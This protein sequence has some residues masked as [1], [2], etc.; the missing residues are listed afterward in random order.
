MSL[1]AV[2]VPTFLQTLKGL[3]TVLGKAEA[4]CEAKKIAQD[5]LLTAR[6]FPDMFT[7]T[8]Q[9][10]SAGD[11][12]AKT[13]ARLAGV[14]VPT[15]PDVEKSF[16]DL[17]QRVATASRLCQGFH[18]EAVRGRRDA[19]DHRAGRLAQLNFN[20][21]SLLASFALP[22]FFFHATTA[23]DILRTERRRG[24]QARFSRHDLRT[25]T[26]PCGQAASLSRRCLRL[27]LRLPFRLACGTEILAF[28]PLERFR[29]SEETEPTPIAN[30]D[31]G[32]F[33]PHLDNVRIRHLRFHLPPHPAAPTT[34][35]RK[36]FNEIVVLI[37]HDSAAG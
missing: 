8:R 34:M 9:V 2:A 24:R 23:Y 18:R 25:L 36:S 10:Q 14:D 28:H 35:H 5:A 32:R 11:F 17:K 15:Y 37:Q 6:L 26:A 27:R 22:N 16:A 19:R 33:R 1:H 29:R 3:S 20:G 21:A 31:A 13:C 12:A 4:H 7:L 30:D